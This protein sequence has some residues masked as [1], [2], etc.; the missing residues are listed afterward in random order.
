MAEEFISRINE[1]AHAASR[2]LSTE[3]GVFGA[4]DMG[5][6]YNCREQRNATC[7][8]IAPTGTISIIADC[9]SG[10][11]PL[12][13]LAYRRRALEGEEL[14]EVNRRFVENAHHNGYHSRELVEMVAHTG[15]VAGVD[16]VPPSA[17]TLF[18]SA[19]DIEPNWHV[20]MQAA[21]QRHVD[22]AVSKTVNLPAGADVESVEEI[23]HLAHELGCKGI[24]V[25]RDGSRDEQ[26]LRRGAPTAIL[27]KEPLTV[28]EEFTA[29]CPVP[30]CDY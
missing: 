26:V 3:R 23:F 30:K 16:G 12:F 18:Q 27:E 6:V 15:S 9:S 19:H 1:E 28:A 11:E 14:L 5:T 13:A 22:N 17:K 21:F 2:S 24:T 7:T 10:I 25:Y 4:H 8:T 20:R 29:G